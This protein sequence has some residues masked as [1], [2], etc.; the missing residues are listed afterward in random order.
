MKKTTLYATALAAALVFPTI[1]AAPVALAQEAAGQ[2]TATA[3]APAQTDARRHVE[4]PRLTDAQRDAMR[5]LHEADRDAS[6]AAQRELRDLR[7]QL[8]KELAATEL[9]TGRIAELKSSILQ[10][11]AAQNAARLE[12]RVR[13]AGILTPEQR[14]AFGARTERM[15]RGDGDRMARAP[16]GM[17]GGHGMRGERG[18]RGV[19]GEREPGMRT[20]ARLRAEVRRLERR[21]EALRRQIR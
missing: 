4:R 11:E 10:K 13:M 20:D 16:R 7:T 2:A 6:Q 15:G 1:G 14:Q 5:K 17:R 18:A 19:R 3:A 12:R 9:N 8:N 21:L